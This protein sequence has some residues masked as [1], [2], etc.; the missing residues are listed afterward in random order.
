M[1]T[2]PAFLLLLG[3]FLVGIRGPVSA[4]AD[5][6]L[7]EVRASIHSELPSAR[8]VLLGS[9]EGS[10]AVV[11]RVAVYWEGRPEPCQV[12]AVGDAR[13]L[14]VDGSGFVLEDMN[15]DGYADFRIQAFVPAGPNTPYLYWLY[16]PET[17]RFQ[18]NKDLEEITSPVFYPDAWEI[19][20]ENR[21]SAI[22][23]VL[24]VYRYVKGKPL[25]VREENTRIDPEEGYREVTV[26]E[27]RDGQWEETSRERMSLWTPFPLPPSLSV[28]QRVTSRPE[29]WEI[30]TDR[31]AHRVSRIGVHDGRLEHGVDLRYDRLATRG[32]SQI[33]TW[34]FAEPASPD[35]Y[36]I[37]VHYT[38]THAVLCRRL[39]EGITS[40]RVIFSRARRID[41]FPVIERIEIR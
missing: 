1:K 23:R 22:A 5:E 31:R 36:W 38:A 4:A 12:V 32:D 19:R 11:E 40:L 34:T 17:R 30:L 27:L 3:L 39:P 37:S 8:F 41:G 15:F 25:L 33:G 24:R 29:G 6:V 28:E 2:R 18:G 21:S 14:S 10:L 16:D 26:R 35:G 20:S 9:R 7:R 13:T